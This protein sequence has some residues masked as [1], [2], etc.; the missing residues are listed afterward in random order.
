MP[1]DDTARLAH[2]REATEQALKFVGGRTRPDLDSDPMLALAL[3]KLVEIIGEAAKQVSHETRA[4]LPSIPWSDAA[5]TRDRLIHHYFDIDLDLL[6]QTQ[7]LTA[8]DS[9][10]NPA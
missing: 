7:L 2:M 8:L 9:A 3:I 10:G 1:P 5:R 6:W 4:R